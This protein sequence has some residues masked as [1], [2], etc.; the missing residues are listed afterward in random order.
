[1]SCHL[2]TA[3]KERVRSVVGFCSVLRSPSTPLTLAFPSL[4]WNKFILSASINLPAH[5][6]ERGLINF[7]DF[8]TGRDTRK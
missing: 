3:E 7:L 5:P 4:P 1:M 8:V 6:L 2:L